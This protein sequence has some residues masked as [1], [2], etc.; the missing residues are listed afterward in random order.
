MLTLYGTKKSRAFRCLWMLEEAGVDYKLQHV[1]FTKGETQRTAHLRINPNGKVPVLVDGECTIVE[2]LAIN[3][4]LARNH[5]P[6][7]WPAGRFAESDAYQW[8]AWAMGELEGPH[9]AAN[10]SGTDVDSTALD[11]SL[12]FLRRR[13]SSQ[14]YIHGEQFSV[15]DLNTAAV[16][17]RPQF[18]AVAF[19]DAHIKEWFNGCVHR[20]ALRRVMAD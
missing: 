1:A 13:L 20:P 7:F 9:D 17:L 6:Q 16:L 14:A 4:H 15:T 19:S 5:A 12:V 10:R 2:S 11:T 3:L 8:L 18:R